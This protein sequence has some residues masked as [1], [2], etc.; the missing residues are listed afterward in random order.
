M[1]TLDQREKFKLRNEESDWVSRIPGNE[2][3][4]QTSSNAQSPNSL[5]S[6]NKPG[7][8]E[9]IGNQLRYGAFPNTI[10]AGERGMQ[11]AREQFADG[12]YA[13]A[14]GTV[15]GTILR[16]ANGLI[17]DTFVEPY[18]KIGEPLQREVARGAINFASGL[19]GIDVPPSV[20][21]ALDAP[22]GAK[23]AA[24]AAPTTPAAKSPL[25]QDTKPA[26]APVDRTADVRSAINTGR[27]PDSVADG[28]IWKS[29]NMYVGKNVGPDAAIMNA[30]TGE[31]APIRGTVSTLDYS[32]AREYTRSLLQDA[33]AQ[34]A[35]A[36]AGASTGGLRMPSGGGFDYSDL[37]KQLGRQPG[38]PSYRYRA[39]MEGVIGMMR[40][41]V[42]ADNNIRDNMTSRANNAA[43]VSAQLRG[44]DLSNAAAAQR[45]A[46]EEARALRDQYNKD[47]EFFFNLSKEERAAREEGEKRVIDRVL[48]MLPTTGD[49]AKDGQMKAQAMQRLN[50]LFGQQI[51]ELRNHVRNNPNDTASLQQLEYLERNGL[52]AFSGNE[53]GLYRY[54]AGSQL[55]DIANSDASW[56]NPLKGE[57][58]GSTEPVTGPVTYVPSAIP[59]HEGYAQLPDGTTV[60]LSQLSYDLRKLYGLPLK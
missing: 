33:A 29:G 15:G 6:T 52:A 54:L 50:Q 18:V 60:R 32:G 35:M 10:A 22:A 57:T 19:T 20:K 13:K 16:Q 38:E 8:L 28:Q 12:D 23:P 59:G 1:T 5:S 17:Q 56:W 41:L 47:R 27:I 25:Q 49:A 40:N 3:A 24:P 42:S 11:K 26:A 48:G 46:L 39:R 30:R 55:R 4:S 36:G 53:E 37:L 45:I 21:K 34:Q 2:R 43:N 14:L 31:R 9:S 7:V 58:T 51:A 44:Q